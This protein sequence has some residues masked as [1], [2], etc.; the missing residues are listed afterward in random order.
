MEAT[1]IEPHIEA[2]LESGEEIRVRAP[3][4]EAT[5]LVTNRRVLVAARDRV[6]LA[7]SF[8]GVRRIQFDIERSRPAT[9]VIVPELAGDEPQVLAIAPEHYEAAAEAIVTLGKTIAPLEPWV[10]PKG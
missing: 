8:E 6:A 4:T 2:T 1:E 5:L 10:R 9:L 3:G 7:I